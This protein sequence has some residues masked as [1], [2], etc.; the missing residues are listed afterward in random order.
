[1]KILKYPTLLNKELQCDVCGCRFKLNKHSMKKKVYAE[2]DNLLI[3]CPYC[4]STIKTEN[5]IVDDILN[6]KYT[7]INEVF[8]QKALEV[9]KSDKLECRQDVFRVVDD[10]YNAILDI[11]EE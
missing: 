1:M 8:R 9:S 2:D 6:A 10:L 7:K 3:S 4:K 11:E 5:S